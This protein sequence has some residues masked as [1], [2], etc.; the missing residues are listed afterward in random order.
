M[1]EFRMPSLGADMEVGT[2]LEW[3]VEPGDAVTRGD[4][5]ALVD[6]EKA[7][8]EVEIWVDGVI[9]R[10]V[11]PVGEQVPVGTVLAELAGDASSEAASS[12]PDSPS[13]PEPRPPLG[14]EPEPKPQPESTSV[15]QPRPPGRVGVKASPR[16]RHLA[17]ELG[18]DLSSVGGTGAEGAIRG[19]DVQRASGVEVE[20]ADF[21]KAAARSAEPR[22]RE[23]SMR[24]AIARAMERSKR[25]IPHYYLETTIDF[26]AAQ[27]WLTAENERREVLRR[28][29][30][31]VLLLKATALALDEVPELNGSWV[32]G[33]FRPATSKHVAM[34]IALRGGGLVAPAVHD[35]DRRDLDALMADLRDLVNRARGGRL[36]SSE[37]TDATITVTSLGDLGVDKVFG[38]IYPPQVA[39]VGFG[40]IAERPFAE[41]G[42]LGIRSTVSVTLAADHRA[43]DG[44]RGSKFLAALA[45]RL[46]HPEQL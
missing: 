8:I 31:A 37:V 46:A 30:P 45:D 16:A 19:A 13:E 1:I 4:I 29:L 39:L 12:E 17:R 41:D 33:G 26:Q 18:V 6:T 34:A 11:V 44:V 24:G 9:E 7:E 20:A 2:V 35:V 23:R 5:V 42:V 36:R 21:R 22:N 25:E 3:L 38:V 15:P 27:S 28:L 14:S 40:R 10:L 32:D 43:S